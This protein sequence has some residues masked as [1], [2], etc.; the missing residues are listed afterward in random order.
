M[1]QL[2]I[3]KYE[4]VQLK[5]DVERVEFLKHKQLTDLQSVSSG[6]CELYEDVYVQNDVDGFTMLKIRQS[7]RSEPKPDTVE[8]EFLRK[9]QKMTKDGLEVDLD[10]LLE[11]VNTELLRVQD[12]KTKDILV[13]IDHE[14]EL[15][16][17]DAP[18]TLAEDVLYLVHDVLVEDV[19][20][21]VVMP[22]QAVMQK[23]LTK[24]LKDSVSIPEPMILGYHVEMGY[25]TQVGKKAKSSNVIVKG[26][27]IDT[28]EVEKHLTS[29]KVVNKLELDNDAVV[30]FKV[31]NT[32]FISGIKF[33]E[34]LKYKEDDDITASLNHLSE[35]QL[36]LPEISK[37]VSILIEEQELVEL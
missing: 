30:Y 29:G 1:K 10:V 32:M 11:E 23:L 26:E 5:V 18:R 20:F 31:D 35:W 25:P 7:K 37:L 4:D 36:K 9:Q 21:E 14:K 34:A 33:E 3:Y 17:V 15:V 13:V 12:I 2:A 6:F 8:R 28:D 16:Y 19:A 24:Y 22:E 27:D